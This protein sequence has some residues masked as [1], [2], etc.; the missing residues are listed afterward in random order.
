VNEYPNVA[1]ADSDATSSSADTVTVTDALR[2]FDE[3]KASVSDELHS[4][5]TSLVEQT[6]TSIGV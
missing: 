1:E 3:E 5:V 2:V 4:S 6:S